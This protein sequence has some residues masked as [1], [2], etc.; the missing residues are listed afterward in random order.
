MWLNNV[1]FENQVIEDQR[2]ELG[3]RNSL[4]FLGRHLTL[5]RC[6]LV[7]NVPAKRLHVRKVQ[8]VDSTIE[9]KRVLKNFRWE[10]AHLKGC[11]FTGDSQATT[12][13]AG[14][15]SLMKEASRRAISV[16]PSWMH[17]ASSGV[18]SAGCASPPG[19]A[20]RSS[21]QHADG[22]NSPCF[23]GLGT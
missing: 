4:Y 23:P 3:D 22:V 9:V 13:E 1:I 15:I 21:S 7:L 10:Y 20:S 16:K 19:H 8:I 5:R 12:L 2:L 11:R 18:T 14:L 17:A 6:N